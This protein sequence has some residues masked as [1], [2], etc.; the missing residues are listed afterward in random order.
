MLA[1]ETTNDVFDQIRSAIRAGRPWSYWSP[2]GEPGRLVEQ[3]IAIPFPD[4]DPNANAPRSYATRVELAL[5]AIASGQVEKVVV[6][7]EEVLPP[8]E[9]VATLEELQRRF[10]NCWVFAISDGSETFLGASPE[11]LARVQGRTLETCA[12]AG[13]AAPGDD[14]LL[15][16]P[17]DLHEHQ[18][19]I[20]AIRL[21]LRP[22]CDEID[23]D[24]VPGLMVLPNVQHLHTAIHATLRTGVTAL[25]IVGALH[26]TPAVC[27]T[28]RD[29]A[30][31]MIGAL[32]PFERGLYAGVVGYDNGTAEFAVAIRSARLC[33]DATYVYAG[34]GIVAGSD[35]VAED[36][37]T[38][39]KLRAVT[40]AL[41]FR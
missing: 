26:P 15:T 2:P 20:D 17:K 33:Q 32:E 12:L 18:L 13:T 9:P 6:A 41:R 22:W 38:R 4:T 10:P 34:A 5:T 1:R 29:G 21:A 11:L 31:R 7:R 8:A 35:P 40:E 30:R 36:H 24:S 23:V 37:E 25:D 28:P 3:L 19:V 27:G 14:A 39:E 16:N